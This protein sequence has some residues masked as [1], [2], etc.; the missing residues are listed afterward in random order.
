[1]EFP[2]RTPPPAGPLATPHIY[3]FAAG[4]KLIRGGAD[5]L[6]LPGAYVNRRQAAGTPFRLPIY[7]ERAARNWSSRLCLSTNLETVMNDSKSAAL[8][9]KAKERIPGGVKDRKSTRLNSSH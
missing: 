4:P 1:M 9:A 3:L 2:N 6:T 7:S 5:S 8:F